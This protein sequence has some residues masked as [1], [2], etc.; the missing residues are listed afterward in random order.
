MA[1]LNFIFDELNINES[2][3]ELDINESSLELDINDS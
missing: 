1:F 3:L 2:S